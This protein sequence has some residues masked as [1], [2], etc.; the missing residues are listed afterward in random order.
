MTGKRPGQH[1]VFDFFQK[2]SPES[3][4]FRIADSN[5]VHSETIWSLAS[6]QGQRVTALN[7]PIT[8]P[9]PSVNG[10][11]VPCGWMPWRQLRLGCH[12][13]GLFDR[14]KTLPSFNAR[15]LALDM[16]LEEKA[17]EG[18]AVEEYADW[19][20]LHT[21]R[22]QRWFELLV[23]LMREEPADLIGIVFD[24]VDKLH[25][26]CWRFMDPALQSPEPSA[27]ELEIARLCEQYF[28]QLD[29]IIAEIVTLA[30]PEA[31]IVMASDHG[32]GPTSEIFYINAW[33]EQAGYL[34]WADG[35][36][37]PTDSLPQL[38]FRQLARHVYKL[39][40]ARTVAYAATPSSQGI[41]IVRRSPDGSNS[42]SDG[43]YRRLQAELREALLRVE[44][45]IN[46]RPII[47]DVR[48]REEEFF[49]P[50]ESL[51]PDL[52]VGLADGAVV[53]ILEADMPV[54][55]RPEVLGSHRAEGIFAASGPGIRAGISLD[56]LSI[57]DVAPLILYSLGL[58]VPSD[59]TGR[60]PRDAIEPA[61]LS[62]RPPR[63]VVSSPSMQPIDTTTPVGA[64]DAEAEATVM[65][66]LRALGYVD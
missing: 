52:S 12:P 23:Y 36:S 34:S 28:R 49:G 50:Y 63:S 37:S 6:D 9:A 46:K 45:P 41:H 39:D 44:D 48:L 66:R 29:D 15:E 38:G 35:N 8:Y 24:G 43:E 20:T 27:W 25:H 19:I 47:T 32:G 33:L 11:V 40:W 60:V 62:L 7:F 14:L 16:A 58:P 59:M 56:E 57:V 4:Y 51:A 1:G 2:E 5:D 64:W 17:I 10:C 61:Q 21:R 18:C 42:M 54:N 22:E 53:S 13:P 31:T 26:L 55:R 3:Q 30:G 65:K